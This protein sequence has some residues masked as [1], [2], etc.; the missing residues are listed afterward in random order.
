M[1][2]RSSELLFNSSDWLVNVSYVI[3]LLHATAITLRRSKGGLLIVDIGH[4][5]QS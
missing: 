2:G 4:P 3:G 1:A 5:F